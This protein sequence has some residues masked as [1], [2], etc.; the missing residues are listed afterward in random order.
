MSN[1]FK[2]CSLHARGYAKR[3]GYCR[4]DGEDELQNQFPSFLFHVC[5]I[6]LVIS[7]EGGEVR[8]ER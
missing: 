3:G 1:N 7:G 5:V 2:E 6:C 8:G 4:N